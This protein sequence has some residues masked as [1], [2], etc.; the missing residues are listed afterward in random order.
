MFNNKWCPYYEFNVVLKEK[1]NNLI[2]KQVNK[3]VVLNGN[4]Y[5]FKNP[6]DQKILNNLFN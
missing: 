3:A 2:Q 1:I 6:I 5:Y 4:Y